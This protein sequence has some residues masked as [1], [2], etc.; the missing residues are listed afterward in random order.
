M[1]RC[2]VGR[3]STVERRAVLSWWWSRV[4]FSNRTRSATPS[5]H[6]TNLTIA[7][8]ANFPCCSFPPL[9]FASSP[10]YDHF[11]SVKIKHFFIGK[12]DSYCVLVPKLFSRSIGEFFPLNFMLIL[13]QRLH[14]K[15]FTENSISTLS[16]SSAN[17]LQE[18]LL[19]SFGF[20]LILCMGAFERTV[21][22]QGDG[23][24]KSMAPVSRIILH[25]RFSQHRL[26]P[27]KSSSVFVL[28]YCKGMNFATLPYPTLLFFSIP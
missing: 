17:L 16:I 25:H 27:Q 7:F 15:I 11:H 4:P 9:W 26:N 3:S 14:F 12:K 21:L 22:W 28:E 23:F 18:I 5:E 20:L 13:Q 24:D 2:L 6:T 1:F 8:S 19:P 10:I